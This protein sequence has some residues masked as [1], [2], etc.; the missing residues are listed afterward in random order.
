MNELKL[1]PD[2]LPRE[3][4]VVWCAA[5]ENQQ[6]SVKTELTVTFQGHLDTAVCA[7][8]MQYGTHCFIQ[9]NKTENITCI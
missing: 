8:N 2:I 5:K 9:K 4:G 3:C 7:A 6:M 1:F